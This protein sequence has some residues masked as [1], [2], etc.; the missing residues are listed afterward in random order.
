MIQPKASKIYTKVVES[1]KE[2]PPL[3]TEPIKKPSGFGDLP[4]VSMK[5]GAAGF[6][7]DSDLLKEQ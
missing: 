7:F 4:P 6:D 1:Q 5:R 2:P 3:P